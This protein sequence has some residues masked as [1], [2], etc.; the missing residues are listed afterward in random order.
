MRNQE[1]KG[2]LT[3]E[4]DEDDPNI[5]SLLAM[6]EAKDGDTLALLAMSDTEDEHDKE[7]SKETILGLIGGFDSDNDTEQE[8][9]K[10]CFSDHE[11]NLQKYS[12][13][14]PESL[15]SDLIDA[16]YFAFSSKEYLMNDCISEVGL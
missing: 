2:E 7:T 12:K 1:I 14:K 4:A 6:V 8:E 13:K 9:T 3:D 11:P 16:Y 5:Q 10:V 15:S